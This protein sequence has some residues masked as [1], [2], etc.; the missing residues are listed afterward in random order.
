MT[1]DG[2]SP[3]DVPADSPADITTD[4]PTDGPTTEPTERDEDLE[5]LSSDLV[6]Y[7]ARLVRAI[8]RIDTGNNA[9]P[10]LRAL[11]L[12]DEF[13]PQTVGDLARADR[14]A[15]ASM[16]GVIAGLLS[17]G[18]VDKQ[19]DPDDRRASIVSLTAAG[20]AELAGARAMHAD[21]VATRLRETG[22]DRHALEL[23]TSVLQSLISAPLAAD[24]LPTTAR[25]QSTRPTTS[26][27]YEGDADTP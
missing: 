8:R 4:T 24:P 11:S 2:A 13:G 17:Q 9:G 7:A 22:H 27:P 15:Q 6:V 18:L 20:Q 21:L 23:A 26:G 12:L 16:S 5:R 1:T 10:G 19:P 3:A 25:A 14:S